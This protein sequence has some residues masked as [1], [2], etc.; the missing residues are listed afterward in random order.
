MGYAL[1]F[2]NRDAFQLAQIN[3]CALFNYRCVVCCGFTLIICG[4]FVAQSATKCQLIDRALF[5]VMWK[6]V[7]INDN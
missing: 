7:G 6:A 3:E 4:S 1:I 2:L 5:V